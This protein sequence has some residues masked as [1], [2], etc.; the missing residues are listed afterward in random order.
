MTSVRADSTITAVPAAALYDPELTQSCM[1]AGRFTSF[2]M[3]I[4]TTG[5]EERA[6]GVSGVCDAPRTGSKDGAR[7]RHDDAEGDHHPQ[8]V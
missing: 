2:T 1:S 8:H 7:A 4:S 5:R 3:K 6:G